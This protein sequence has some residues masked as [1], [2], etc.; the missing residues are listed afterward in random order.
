[1]LQLKIKPSYGTKTRQYKAIDTRLPKSTWANASFKILFVEA[2]TKQGGGKVTLVGFRNFSVSKELPVTDVILKQEL[3]LRIKAKKVAKFKAGKNYQRKSP[4]AEVKKDF[5]NK[6]FV[7]NNTCF[8][9]Q[10]F[11]TAKSNTKLIFEKKL[12]MPYMGREDKNK[13]RKN[14]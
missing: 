8:L 7:V 6:M 3:L 14:I 10:M 11:F 12:E 5:R 9:K 4:I 2:V 1:L 13:K